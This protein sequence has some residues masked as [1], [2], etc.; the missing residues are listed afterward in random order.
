MRTLICLCFVVVTAGLLLVGCKEDSSS[1]A[2]TSNQ[3][4]AAAPADVL[5]AGFVLAQAPENASDVVGLKRAKPGDEVVLRGRVGG[6]VEP[7]VGGRA[8]F[9]VVDLG[10]KSCKELEG[11]ACKT[12]WD[13]CCDPEV[14]KKSASIQVVGA[15]GKPLHTTLKGV[16]GMQ[17]LS[18]VTIKGKVAQASESGPLIVNATGI[19]VKN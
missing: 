16:A 8:A 18:E 6:R 10:Q 11:D 2:K 5:P 9:Q 4:Q 19:Y 12:P 3:Q 7:F 17:P 13:Y 15:D 14:S 1:T